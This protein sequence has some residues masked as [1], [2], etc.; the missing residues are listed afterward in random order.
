MRIIFLDIDGV[1]NSTRTMLVWGS[2]S[3]P[4]TQFA[5]DNL[6]RDD[7]LLDPVAVD[8]LRLLVESVDAKIVVSST[9]RL[10]LRSPDAFHLMFDLYG[11]DTRDVV[12]GMTPVMN[13]Q[14]GNEIE[15][16]IEKN[17]GVEQYV[18]LDDDS[19]M[20]S[21]QLPYFVNTDHEMGFGHKDF[22]KAIAVFGVTIGD[23]IKVRNSKDV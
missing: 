11:W 4:F 15:R 3:I 21:N 18:I 13:V 10:G 22:E 14:R 9:W 20:L 1:L 7:I 16:W 8:M 19:D 12:I 2:G 5:L 6:C 23:V 17:P